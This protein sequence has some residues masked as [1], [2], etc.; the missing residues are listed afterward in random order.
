MNLFN[1]E[2]DVEVLF[3]FFYVKTIL[4]DHEGI[5]TGGS[6]QKFVCFLLFCFLLTSGFLFTVFRTYSEIN[7]CSYTLWNMLFKYEI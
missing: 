2:Q 5:S 7:N 3:L 1:L 4:C 6:N